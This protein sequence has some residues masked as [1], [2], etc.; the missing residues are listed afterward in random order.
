MTFFSRD[1][2]VNLQPTHDALVGVDSDGCVFD[3][4]EIKQKQCFHG[5]IAKHWNLQQIENLVRETA[6]F[7]NLYSV[8]RG[9]NRFPCLLRTFDLL[10]SRPEA[11]QPQ[12]NLPNCDALRAFVNSGRP[13]SNAEL[14]KMA[15]ETNNPDL[16]SLLAWSEAVNALIAEKARK[17]PPF[18]QAVQG[19]L[20][21][22]KHADAI[23]VSQTP[24]AAIIREWKENNLH[25]FVRV[26]AGQE[27]GA[28]TEHLKLA[29]Q[30][31][32]QP[33]RV[34]MIG[35]ACGDRDA[36]RQVGALFY[37]IAPGHENESWQ[38][39]HEEAF[40]LF[41]S[42]GFAGAYEAELI[43]EFEALLPDTPPWKTAT[44]STSTR[45]DTK[46]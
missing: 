5:L 3:S 44:H 39:F 43:A 35:D 21:I 38:R 37:P 2:L 13:L 11:N 28:K 10:R 12:I 4:M 32:Y 9:N 19:L 40:A 15:A 46:T 17:I 24:T 31:K 25:S 7:V 36:A 29:M 33:H 41:L 22:N 26:I 14:S 27:L 20:K 30:G 6:E 1:D 8:W 34:L 16:A 45:F 42:G 23:C 18:P